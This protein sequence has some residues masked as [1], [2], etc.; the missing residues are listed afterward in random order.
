[1]AQ[2]NTI[3]GVDEQ[4]FAINVPYNAN[5]PVS[6]IAPTI[7]LTLATPQ[8][9]DFSSGIAN[10]LSYTQSAYD[11]Q[12]ANVD[13]LNQQ[14]KTESTDL[15]KLTSQMGGKGVDT[16]L[17]YQQTGATNLAAEI[18][19]LNAQSNALAMDTQAK[20]LAEQNKATGQN[21]TSQAVQRNTA[22][23]TRENFI[24]QANIA[25]QVAI[26]TADYQ[27]AKDLADQI[28]NAK[29]DQLEANLKAKQ[30][31]LQGLKDYSL[32]PAER[33]LAEA[34]TAKL[35]KEEQDLADKKANDLAVNK[36]IIDASPVAPVDV[37]QRAKDIQAKGGSPTEVAIALGKYG[38]DYLG[39]LVK[40]STIRKNDADYEKTIKEIKALGQVPQ[41]TAPAGT[42]ANFIQNLA[43]SA[44]NKESLTQTERTAVT[45]NL[46]V[47]DQLDVLQQN[48]AKQNKTGFIKGKVNNLL[49][50]VGQNADV[51]TIN[52]QLQAI[53]P[54]LARGVYG[55][56]GV[57]TDNDIANYRK[58]L[59]LLTM[60]KDQNDAILALTLKVVQKNLKNTLDTAA[61]SKMDVS[62][63]AP[64]YQEVTNKIN[65]INDR[66]GVSKQEVL[67]YGRNNP[68]A[69]QMIAD[70]SAQGLK[71]SEILQVLG[72]EN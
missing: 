47:L 27:T 34:T 69:Q 6:S 72:V 66:I 20:T 65:E 1:M 8:Y 35:K 30:I 44:V 55:E 63:F 33:K 5:I 13:A 2:E 32:T 46:T 31:N 10:N 11:N 51:G 41:I 49:A 29:Y 40:R 3:G 53:V 23:A 4:G 24:N 14:A 16:N 38:G 56:V 43:A 42:N 57:L 12:V 36:L 39:D 60:P 48:I 25:M 61:N 58:T 54:N 70:L 15:A 37:L 59:P 45:K 52:A 28:V 50:A 62:R 64:K 71:P 67:E 9:K 17:A 26:K 18:R 7:P 21:I 22:D 68:Q 19:K